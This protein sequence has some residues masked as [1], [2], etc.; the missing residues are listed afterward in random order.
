MG[1]N[2]LAYCALIRREM[3]DALGGHD[4]TIPYTCDWDFWKRAVRAG[5]RS[6][7]VPEPLL[8]YRKHPGSMTARARVRP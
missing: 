5:Y 8:H 4:E 3:W 2:H 7:H 6:N 1:T